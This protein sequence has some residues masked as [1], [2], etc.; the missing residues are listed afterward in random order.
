LNEAKRAVR[1]GHPDETRLQVSAGITVTLGELRDKAL[2]VGP[3]QKIAYV[4]DAG[5]TDA[6]VAR[7]V[8][9]ARE[10]DQLFIEAAF[11]DED[12]TTA[13]GKY[14]LTAAQAGRIGRMARARHLVP[15]HHSARYLDRPDALAQ[16]ARRA[17]HGD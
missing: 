17:F 7:I 11:L 12:S 14:H 8:A 2:R 13:A 4:T 10:A 5:Y 6:N 16:E 3:G 1:L 9:L 15:F